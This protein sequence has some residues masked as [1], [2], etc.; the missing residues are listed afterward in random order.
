MLENRTLEE[1]ET[2]RLGES[3]EIGIKTSLSPHHATA[4]FPFSVGGGGEGRR[5]G[6]ET[7]AMLEEILKYIL[8]KMEHFRCQHLIPFSL[9]HCFALMLISV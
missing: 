9:Q 1:Q 4:F 6:R 8:F 3:Y 7:L 2:R 5:R